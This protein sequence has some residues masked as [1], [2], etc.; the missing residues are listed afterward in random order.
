ML[1]FLK[2]VTPMMNKQKVSFIRCQREKEDL[3]TFLFKP[4]KAFS[5]K[6]GQHGIF[7]IQHTNISKPTRP[8]SLSSAPSEPAIAITTRVSESPSEYKQALMQL[9]TG[10]TI[11]MRGPIGPLYLEDEVPSLLIAGG[12]GITPFRSILKQLAEQDTHPP[13]RLLYIDSKGTLLFKDELDTF[14][15]NPNTDIIYLKSRDAL[16]K[17]IQAYV[18]DYRDTANYYIGGSRTMVKSVTAYL[19]ENGISKKDIRKDLFFGL[20]H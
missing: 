16:Q 7:T 3:Y 14:Q 11:E 19:N 4:E 8:F 10:D 6:A 1:R 12:I 15:H 2:D 20:K 9:K 17:E 5:W 18:K 13:V